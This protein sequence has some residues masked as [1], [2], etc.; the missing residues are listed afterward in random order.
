MIVDRRQAADQQIGESLVP[1]VQGRMTELGLWPS[2]LEQHHPKATLGQSVWGGTEPMPDDGPHA[3]DGPAWQVDRARFGDW[4]REMAVQGGAALLTPVG[5]G[6][7]TR[8]GDSWRL[9]LMS[10]ER[11]I[12]V[13]AKLLIDAG[14]RASTLAR[15]CG[16]RRIAEDR[17][18]CRWVEGTDLAS[19]GLTHI[20]AEPDGW[21]YTAPLAGDRRVVAFYTDADLLAATGADDADTFLRRLAGCPLLSSVL[22]VGGFAVSGPMGACAAHSTRLMQTAGP[23]WFAVGD[24]AFSLDPLSPTGAVIALT[25]GLAAA[26]A[27]AKALAGDGT[28][29]ESYQASTDAMRAAGR[30]HLEALYGLERRWSDRPFWQRRLRSADGPLPPPP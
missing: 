6:P 25:T 23:G 19:T 26:D 1:G 15:T 27:A 8:D 4:L 29:P 24:A 17:L 5:I 7:V 13:R 21:W 30:M 3:L 16:T 10:R 28:V 22:S 2:F 9:E 20:E 12:S 18:V 11:V 14:G